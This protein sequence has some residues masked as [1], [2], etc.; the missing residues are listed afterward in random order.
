MGR[1]HKKESTFARAA[2]HL[3]FVKPDQ[4]VE[5]CKAILAVQRDHGNREVRANARMKYLVHTLGIHGF[6]SLVEEY[7]GE[8]ISPI[9]PMKEWKFSDWL[10]WHDQG[11]GKMFKGFWV[12]SGRIRDQDG[13]NVK[14]A[15]RTL[16]DEIECDVILTPNQN[17]VVS[18]IAPENKGRVDEILA[19]NGIE[20]NEKALT[21][22]HEGAIAC[23]ALP[24]CG[25]AITEAERVLPEYIDRV[26]KLMDTMGLGDTEMIFRMTGCPNGCGR[27]YMAELGLV[28]SGPDKYQIWLGGTRE[29]D[30]T[31]WPYLDMVPSDELEATLEPVFAL[32]KM[33]RK[34]N[35]GFGNFCKRAGKA[36][37]AAFAEKYVP[38]SYK[39]IV[40]GKKVIVGQGKN[41]SLKVDEELHT[42][43]KALAKK[44]KMSMQQF[45]TKI[46]MDGIYGMEP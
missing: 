44:N 6:R 27:P 35:E 1:T 39:D 32:Y 40:D 10:G 26:H 19:E 22:L 4:V 2:D 21:P 23:A 46:L 31:G 34:T 5:L 45:T 37:I 25:L 30:G 3:G 24:L 12:S 15:L 29:L 11:D 18:N 20:A 16:V 7:F 43:I 42:R 33:R 8:T 9:K 13:V 38:G 28:G 17:I 36:Q 41:K 14:T